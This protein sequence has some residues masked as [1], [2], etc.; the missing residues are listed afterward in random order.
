VIEHGQETVFAPSRHCRQRR[1]HEAAA[2]NAEPPTVYLETRI[3]SE[4]EALDLKAGGLK[5]RHNPPS[6]AT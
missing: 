3:G 2:L 4:L 6:R 5:L 1:A